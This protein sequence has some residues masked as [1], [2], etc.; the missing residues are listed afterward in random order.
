MT[1]TI[2][3]TITKYI[4]TCTEL[5][6]YSTS[7]SLLN[8][9][10]FCRFLLKMSSISNPSSSSINHPSNKNQKT[11]LINQTNKT[12]FPN[13][14]EL[15][16]D[17]WVLIFSK[18]LT[19]EIIENVQKVCMLFRRICKQPVTF[20]TINMTVPSD[21][22]YVNLPRNLDNMTRY[23]IDS[24]AGGL[25]DI[26]LEYQSGYKYHDIPHRT[27]TYITER[28]KN[29]KHLRLGYVYNISLPDERLIEAVKKLPMLEEI[30]MIRCSF[31]HKTVEA[32][33]HACP[34]LTSFGLNG[35]CCK[36]PD[37]MCNDEDYISYDEEYMSNDEIYVRNE[38]ALAISKSMP[39]LRHLQLIGNSM[40][41]EGLKAI[42][43][44]CPHLKSLDLR[45]CFHIDLSGDLG[46]FHIDLSGDLGKRLA[47]VHLLYPNDSTA[48]YGHESYYMHDPDYNDYSGLSE[49]D[50]DPPVFDDYD[51]YLDYYSGC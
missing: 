41:N 2:T 15:L 49:S 14:L 12:Q 6:L 27:L 3:I 19:I 33:G 22:R 39:K 42:L 18:L 31:S 4:T 1:I 46:C 26:Y 8:R 13:W 35:V 25:I 50:D 11:D 32:I 21:H 10:N 20:R 51:D 45:S 44:G 30:Q 17:I 40:N 43:D 24:S 7:A 16:E 48:D 38:E 28:C 37:N 34:S 23:A 36:L 9:L 47:N 29:L 5:V